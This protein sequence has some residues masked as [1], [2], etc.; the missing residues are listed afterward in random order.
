MHI[1]KFDN[2][3]NG[4]MTREE[5]NEFNS[6]LNSSSEN[7]AEFEEYKIIREITENYKTDHQPSIG[8]AW[9]KVKAR[10]LGKPDSRVRT[11]NS[12]WIR[13]AASILLI[14]AIGAGIYFTNSPD[15]LNRYTTTYSSADSL[16]ELTLT[17]GSQVWLNKS[18]EL[19]ISASFGE[20]DRKVKLQGEAYFEVERNESLPFII[21]CYKSEV[22]VLGTSF[23][24]KTD[25]A[26][27]TILNV[28]NGKVSFNTPVAA[29][30]QFIL[31][32]GD[33]IS[34]NK[35]G[36]TILSHGQR[37][38]YLAWKEGVFRF[39]DAEL[40]TVLHDLSEFYGCDFQLKGE[41][42]DRKRL[43]GNFYTDSLEDILHV[44]SLSLNLKIE[45]T[46]GC[47]YVIIDAD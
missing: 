24:I 13:I 47:S 15:I 10:S 35:K 19:M 44:I 20:K 30:K 41:I 3:L 38:N 18:S 46:A 42:S 39:K 28:K 7:R 9:D 29:K 26:E 32:A 8:L 36:N 25:K 14:L 4:K 1:E 16:R 22:K 5:E 37:V 33:M 2:Y 43:S 27:G 34:L 45:K 40:K 17:D 6:W 23:N 11:M 31:T 12:P 21:D